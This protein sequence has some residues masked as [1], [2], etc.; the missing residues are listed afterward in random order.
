MV[1]GRPRWTCALH[2]VLGDRRRRA[3]MA[4]VPGLHG[5][6]S[7]SHN[8]LLRVKLGE[9]LGCQAQR[10]HAPHRAHIRGQVPHRGHR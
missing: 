9:R 5:R 4:S 10:R 8:K 6:R 7:P 1:P 3:Q 2:E